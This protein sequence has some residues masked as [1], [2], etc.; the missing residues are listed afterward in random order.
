[1]AVGAQNALNAHLRRLFE[2]RRPEY[3]YLEAIHRELQ[4][5]RFLFTEG[6]R[7]LLQSLADILAEKETFTWEIWEKNSSEDASRDEAN[8]T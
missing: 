2:L 8:P 5:D 7:E 3:T 4:S 1:M 6:R